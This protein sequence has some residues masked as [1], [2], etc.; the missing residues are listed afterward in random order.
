[1]ESSRDNHYKY[2]VDNETVRVEMPKR[3]NSTLKFL[4][5]QN[6]FNVPFVIYAD[7][8]SILTPIEG[9][10]PDPMTPYTKKVNQHI[11]SGWCACSTFTYGEKVKDPLKLYRGKDC[12]EK[13]CNYMKGEAKRLSHM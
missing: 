1:M 8:E 9:P 5:G 7:F 2:C 4:D 3:K 11:P 12:V 6:Q 10:I 13:F